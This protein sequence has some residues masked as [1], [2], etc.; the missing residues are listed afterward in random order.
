MAEQLK[1]SCGCGWQHEGTEEHD[2]AHALMHHARD[3]HGVNLSHDQ[4]H[5]K[6]RE[7]SQEK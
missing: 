1:V 6:V 3:H 4:A 5:Q 2:V 7:Q